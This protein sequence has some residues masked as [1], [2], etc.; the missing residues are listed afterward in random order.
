MNLETRDLGNGITAAILKG[1][2]DIEGAA[3]IDLKFNALAGATKKLIVDLSDV[4]F[5]ASLG[6]RTLVVGA[7]A[8][9]SKGGRMVI[10][11]PQASVE[12]VL[13]AS[14]LDS[15]IPIYADQH[16]AVVALG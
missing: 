2:L 3:A 10:A 16:A 13:K 7:K 1:R 6:L 14:S 15:V 5:V 4:S 9:A 11:N 12:K 8:I